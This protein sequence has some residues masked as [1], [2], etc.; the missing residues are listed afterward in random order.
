VPDVRPLAHHIAHLGECSW[1]FCATAG[2]AALL[3]GVKQPFHSSTDL[4]RHRGTRYQETRATAATHLQPAVHVLSVSREG[5]S[6]NKGGVRGNKAPLSFQYQGGLKRSSFS[7]IAGLAFPGLLA[8]SLKDM[9]VKWSRLSLA[10][11]FTQICMHRWPAIT[12]RSCSAPLFGHVDV[13][14]T[15][16]WSP[17]VRHR[18]TRNRDTPSP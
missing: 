9:N 1:W 6:G 7:L 3:P 14:A 5:P 4:L 16:P 18:R 8:Q 15:T 10:G 13:V 12:R 11:L 17:R 2:S